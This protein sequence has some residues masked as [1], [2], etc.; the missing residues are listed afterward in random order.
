MKGKAWSTTEHYFQAQKFADTEHEEAVRCCSGPMNAAKM[1]RDRSLPLRKDWEEVKEK[2]MMDAL[3]AK[4]EQHPNI[5]KLLL[6]TG[7]EVLVEHTV[8][9]S[10]W[11][12]GGDGSGKNRLGGL[13][14][15]LRSQLRENDTPLVVGDTPAYGSFT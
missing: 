9:D 5:K 11:G 15:E 6:S 12:D 10:Y 14:M 4:M 2:V 3:I 8:N 7:D 1:G 13:L